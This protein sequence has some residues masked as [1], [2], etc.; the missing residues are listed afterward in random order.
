MTDVA[1]VK[2]YVDVYIGQKIRV[3]GQWFIVTGIELSAEGTSKSVQLVGCDP[4]SAESEQARNMQGE[5]VLDQLLEEVIHLLKGSGG[6][7]GASERQ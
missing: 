5:R 4:T 1:V 6:S 3:F 7:H 2:D